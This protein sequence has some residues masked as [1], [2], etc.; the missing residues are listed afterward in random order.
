M[1]V[2]RVCEMK[3]DIQSIQAEL[4]TQCETLQGIDWVNS[5]GL[6]IQRASRFL[7]PEFKESLIKSHFIL[8]LIRWQA[9]RPLSI[10]LGLQ[11]V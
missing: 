7:Y 6:H 1:I 3:M 2:F 8:N 9:P 5:I 10:E 4:H 11:I